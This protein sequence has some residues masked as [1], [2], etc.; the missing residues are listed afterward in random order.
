L[1][2]A[3]AHISRESPRVWRIGSS[4][5]D[6]HKLG[7]ISNGGSALRETRP[8]HRGLTFQR[9]SQG[10]VVIR[11]N[12]TVNWTDQPSPVGC[13]QHIVSEGELDRDQK[14]TNRSSQGRA[15]AH[16]SKRDSD[17]SQKIGFVSQNGAADSYRFCFGGFR[18]HTPGP[19]P[20]SSMNSM[21]AELQGG[22]VASAQKLGLFRKKR[23]VL[24]ASALATS[25]V[26]PGSLAR[27]IPRRAQQAA[28]SATNSLNACLFANGLRFR[29]LDRRRI[30]CRPAQGPFVS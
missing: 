13:A 29:R 15:P 3:V 21:P 19:P 25:E 1:L 30:E 5:V 11:S 7:T 16:A 2:E 9:H 23:S 4:F 8:F 17:L 18:R 26:D 12:L 20:I 22:A 27:R 10:T 6:T 14:L 28:N 24:I